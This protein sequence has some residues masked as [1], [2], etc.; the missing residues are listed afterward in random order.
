MSLVHLHLLLNH[1][2]I[3]GTIFIIALLADAWLRRNS[4]LA[5]AALGAAVVVGAVAIAVYFTGEPAEEAVEH[6]PGVTESLI[7]RHEDAAT[8]ATIGAGI[9]GAV[10]AGV[11]LR[12][13]GRPIARAVTLGSLVSALALGGLMGWT[14]N[15]GGQIRHSEIRAGATTGSADAQKTGEKAD[16][17]DDKTRSDQ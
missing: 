16:N 13:R 8:I 11:L 14:S 15:L 9:L 3:I 5:K 10:A 17:D 12:F 7:E 4:D 1:I 6:L 2:P